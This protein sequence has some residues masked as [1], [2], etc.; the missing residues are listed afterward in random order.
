MTPAGYC[1]TCGFEVDIIAQWG[2]RRGVLGFHTRGGGACKG[3][4]RPPTPS[5]GEDERFAF[6]TTPPA[7]AQC[8]YCGGSGIKILRPDGAMDSHSIPGSGLR[9]AGSYRQ[10][11]KPT[12]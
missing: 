8:G 9:C 12:V 6:S 2:R 1:A 3:S 5:P 7:G 11:M 4:Y 10:P